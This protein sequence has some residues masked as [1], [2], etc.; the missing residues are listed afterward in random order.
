[1]RSR[2]GGVRPQTVLA[3]TFRRADHFQGFALSH[4]R[5]ALAAPLRNGSIYWRR[6]HPFSRRGMCSSATYSAFLSPPMVLKKT[7]YRF[8]CYIPLAIGFLCDLI[9]AGP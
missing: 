2:G 9:P 5:F 6:V 1:M 7:W 8:I 4:S 3:S